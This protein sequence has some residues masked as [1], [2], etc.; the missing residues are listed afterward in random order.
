MAQTYLKSLLTVPTVIKIKV[1]EVHSKINK[2]SKICVV[3]AKIKS[4]KR[5][6]MTM[7]RAQLLSRAVPS[8]KFT[9][10]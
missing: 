4:M 6:M 8:M 3:A 10:Y 2:F 7:N 5:M 1:S 9:K